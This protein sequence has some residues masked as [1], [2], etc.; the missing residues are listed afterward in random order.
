MSRSPLHD[1]MP[2]GTAFG[3]A[4]EAGPSMQMT[5]ATQQHIFYMLSMNG[6]SSPSL[7]V[8]DIYTPPCRAPRALADLTVLSSCLLVSSSLPSTHHRCCTSRTRSN[9]EHCCRGVSSPSDLSRILDA[10]FSLLHI[11]ILTLDSSRLVRVM[12]GS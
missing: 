2:L 9:S 5:R 1:V 10:F 6:H 4:W 7:R 12:D 11:A 8:I 3:D